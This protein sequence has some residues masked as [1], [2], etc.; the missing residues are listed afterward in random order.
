[1]VVRRSE[2]YRQIAEVLIR[3]GWSTLA[4]QS[5]VLAH[6]RPLTALRG[7]LG[8]ASAGTQAARTPG[9][10][11]LR[12]AL[13]ELG[14]TFMK[15]GQMLATR[16]DILPTSYAEELSRLQDDVPPVPVEQIYEVITAE[17]GG[18]VQDHFAYFDEAPLASGTIGQAHRARL[19][20]G[21]AVVVKV[22]RPGVAEQV[23][24]DLAILREIAAVASR[25]WDLAA[26][27]DIVGLVE[28]FDRTLRRELDY[29]AEA[30][31]AE[32]FRANLAEDPLVR[33]PRLF[34]DLSSSQV[35]T[36]EE[37]TGLRITDTAA[38]RERGL[39]PA[40]LAKG[41]TRTVIHIVLVDGFFHADPHPGNLFVREDGAL[42]LID[43]GMVG[44]LSEPVRTQMLQL[45]LALA[46]EDAEAVMEHLLRMAPPKHLVDRPQLRRD[47]QRLMETVGGDRLATMRMQDFFAQLTA[48]LRRHRMQLPGEIAALLRMLVLTES[49]ATILDPDIHLADVLAEVGRGA[50]LRELSPESLLRRTLAE[51]QRAAQFAMDLPG[52]AERLLEDYEA[53]G[54]S[55]QLRTDALEPLVER[56][57]ATGD[58]VVAGVTMGALVVSVGTILASDAG[59]LSRVRDP[60]MLAA[61]GA[62]GLL[63]AYLAAGAGP[64]RSLRRVVRRLGP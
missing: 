37:A 63:G 59:P 10:V 22:R 11:R 60:L 42:W 20:D 55:V 2:R 49:T 28:T 44:E 36:M 62:A 34:P 9:P 17:L 52:R 21:T 6:V 40:A 47:V 30:A 41:A 33:I 56:V 35:L 19:K 25:E 54:V 57:E 51:G 58:R 8:E 18:S 23:A 53:H 43:F 13:E 24:A 4:E 16:Q 48:L 39:D 12:E 26:D 31:N 64:A 1:M 27:L 61:G 14:P 45:V 46:R 29:H 5:G 7:L 38:L 15:L 32:R 50:V 3:S